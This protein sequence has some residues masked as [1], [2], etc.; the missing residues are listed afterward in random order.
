MMPARED[1]AAGAVPYAPCTAV[2]PSLA[3]GRGRGASV[4]RRR[5]RGRG[6]ARRRARRRACKAAIRTGPSPCSCAI[7]ATSSASCR[8]CAPRA[9]A[10][11]RSRS[12][13][14]DGGR[15]CRTCSR[16]PAR[17]RIRPIGS[18]GSRCF[19]RRGAGSPLPTS[20]R[21]PKATEGRTVWELLHDDARLARVGADGAARLDQNA[22]RARRSR[23]RRACARVCASRSRTHGS[24][25]A[26]RP[27]SDD[28]A[29]EDA[30]GL[31][32]RAGGGR[33]GG[34]AARPRAV[35]GADRRAVGAAGRARGRDRRADHDDPQGERPRVRPRDRPRSRAAAA[36]RGH[37]AL[38][39]DRAGGA[40]REQSCW[41]RPS[42]ATGADNEPIYR[43]IARST[44]SAR[45]HEA[46]RLL[47]VAATRARCATAS[48][49][50]GRA[51]PATAIRA[52]RRAGTLL[53]K[54]WPVVAP[55]FAEA[56]A[57]APAMAY[58]AALA[59]PPPQDLARLAAD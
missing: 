47:Y 55:R 18:P 1:A 53:A 31:S 24:R 5:L 19:A 35:R 36:R 20:A 52:R 37:A 12:S 29:L 38:P 51:R 9:C 28:T 11:A 16:S 44:R 15:W 8:G 6:G 40:A 45:E 25:S 57:A 49:W 39:L 13:S 48:A 26:G 10:S 41:S 2:H 56:A 42:K 22:H 27:A 21:S 50:R 59:R 58:G 23:R 46:A 33:G 14:S 30:G 43:R 3:G 17:R 7:A 54:L 4:L 32:R 34:R